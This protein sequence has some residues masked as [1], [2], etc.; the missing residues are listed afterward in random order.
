MT[1]FLT[2]FHHHLQNRYRSRQPQGP[3][4]R[5]QKPRRNNEIRQPVVYRIFNRNIQHSY[6]IVR[7][8]F[9][10]RYYPWKRYQ[11]GA[12]LYVIDIISNN[13][14]PPLCQQ[15]HTTFLFLFSFLFFSI[16]FF[17]YSLA[18][19]L[20]SVV[21][22]VYCLLLRKTYLL[23]DYRWA[24]SKVSLRG[25]GGGT[26]VRRKACETGWGHV[27]AY[28]KFQP[29][30]ISRKSEYWKFP[31][32]P[33]HPVLSRPIPRRLCQLTASD[34]HSDLARASLN[35]SSWHSR[36]LLAQ[37]PPAARLTQKCVQ[38]YPLLWATVSHL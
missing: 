25:G 28:G 27:I 13:G 22:L 11:K 6:L 36:Q 32:S 33:A 21:L 12:P 3:K 18:H 37:P 5:E 4:M 38:P 24:A 14:L 2:H 19:Y 31:M 17:P 35:I 10:L 26:K 23:S 7:F 34:S 29:S 30:G 1:H 9:F 16:P 15:K 20:S 8:V